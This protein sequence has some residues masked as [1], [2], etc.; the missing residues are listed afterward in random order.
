[1]SISE[2]RSLLIGIEATARYQL[3][4]AN[5]AGEQHNDRDPITSMRVKPLC[6]RT[7]PRPFITTLAERRTTLG[8][9]TGFGQP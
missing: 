6:L 3:R 2:T 8:E 7:F 4:D 9:G 1:M 5:D